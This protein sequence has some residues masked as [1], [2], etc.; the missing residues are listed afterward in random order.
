MIYIIRAEFMKL[1]RLHVLL[2]GMIGMAFPAILSVFTQS[3]TIPEAKI[4]DFNF[5][6]LFNHT[7]WNSTTTFMPVIFTLV[8]GYLINREYKDD[9]LKNIFTI[10]ISFHKLVL[11]KL[12]AMGIISILFGFYSFIVTLI[13]GFITRI[14]GLNPTVLQNSFL[15][16][17]G[18]SICTYI[19]VLPIIAFTCRKRDAFMGGVVVSFLFGYSSMFIKD[20][21]LRSLYPILSGLTIIRFNTQTYMNTAE[22]G[23]LTISILTMA[24]ILLFTG[25]LILMPYP[26]KALY[27]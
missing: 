18:I 25:M 21:T 17:T 16:M 5:T 6:V 4:Q 13:V 24:A 8:G 3:V 26:R 15:Q 1:R 20:V 9:T 27:T 10:P 14:N 22:S 19:S 11:G 7:I 2:I 23:N 12:I